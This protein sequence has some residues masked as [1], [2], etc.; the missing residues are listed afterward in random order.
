MS[1]AVGC[2][3]RENTQECRA[4]FTQ[5]RAVCVDLFH[6]LLFLVTFFTARKFCKL[7][8]IAERGKVCYFLLLFLLLVTFINYF[9]LLRMARVYILF[10]V[11]QEKGAPWFFSFFFKL[12][13]WRGAEVNVFFPLHWKCGRRKSLHWPLK[14]HKSHKFETLLEGCIQNE[15]FS[16]CDGPIKPLW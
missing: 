9:L 10:I 6:F 16:F 3:T 1:W 11:R 12:L 7:I 5:C 4:V 2:L 13:R 8:F 15:F 14:F